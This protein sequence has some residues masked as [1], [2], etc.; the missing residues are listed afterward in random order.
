MRDFY[1]V[2]ILLE[3]QIENIDFKVLSKATMNTADK[4]NTRKIL[5]EGDLILEEI[6]SDKNM[7]KSWANYQSKYSY[8]EDISW[9]EIKQSVY[10]MWKEISIS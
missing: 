3:L 4:R 7:L 8:A 5:S 9:E 1:D 10:M 6:F 2:Y